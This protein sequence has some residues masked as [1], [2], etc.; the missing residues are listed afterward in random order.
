VSNTRLRDALSGAAAAGLAL[1]VSELVAGLVGWPSLL[2]GVGNWVIDNVPTPVKEWAI[3]TFGTNDKL[4][5]GI[6]IGV[7][8]VMVG[9]VVGVLARDRFG[10]AVTVFIAFGVLGAVAASADPQVSLGLAILPGGL[11]A[12]TGL[13]ALQWLYGLGNGGPAPPEEA[14]TA[15]TRRA[16]VLGIGA[17]ALTAVVSVTVGRLLVDRGARMAAGRTTVDLPPPVEP[18]LAPGPDAAFDLAE[19]SP[20]VTPTADFYRIDT[21]FTVPRVDVESW[22]LS[23]TGMVDQPYTVTYEDIL[24]MDLVERYVTLSC[25]SNIVGGDL[26]GNARW[27][28]VPLSQVLDRAGLQAGAT[29]IVGRA[30]DG[31]TVGFPTELVFDGRDA[32]LAV[33]MNGEPLPIEHGFPARM[34][35]AGLYGYVSATKW[36][37]EIELTT[38]EAFDA[39]WVPLGWSKEGPVKTQS[40]IDTPRQARLTYSGEIPVAGV[41]WAPDRGISKVEVQ[42]GADSPWVE[43][44]LSAP[45]SDSTWVQWMIPWDPP[46]GDHT[47]Q[48]RA[49]DGEGNVQTEERTPPAPNG[50]SG[51]DR[52]TVT[53][54]PA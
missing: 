5:L 34:V 23:I 53:I 12:I 52:H 35:V 3:A 40:R 47:I 33:G 39:Y 37:S 49:T 32:L 8:V 43:A 13:A 24:D 45:L 9:A 10:L 22:T 19:L 25:V 17:V 26:V 54:D 42:L 44:E 36:L 4:V 31:F 38:W 16:V 28:G 2:T 20:I 21:A 7:V 18:V 15:V 41:A 11:A 50:A 14:E 48:V 27:L 46:I 1:G 30:V 6:G 29:Q 51:W